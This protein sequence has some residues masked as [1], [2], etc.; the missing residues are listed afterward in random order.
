VVAVAQVR[1][2]L[3]VL[4]HL[5]AAVEAMV[6]HLQLQAHQLLTLVA[7]AVV[8]TQEAHLLEQVVLVAAAL[9]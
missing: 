8:V 6:L 3:L 4:E 1:L 7:A 9:A 5:Q 2:A